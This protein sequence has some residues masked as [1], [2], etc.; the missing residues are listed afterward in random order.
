MRGWG[1]GVPSRDLARSF[2]PKIWPGPPGGEGGGP[3]GGGGRYAVG[4]SGESQNPETRWGVILSFDV[5]TYTA[6][7]YVEGS[8]STATLPVAK[9]LT[10]DLLPTGTKVAI[11]SFDPSNPD[12]AIVVGTYG[13]VGVAWVTTGI[14]VDDCVTVGKLAHNIDATGIGFDADKVDGLHAAELGGG[15][16]DDDSVTGAKISP[17]AVFG[18]SSK[19]LV[20]YVPCSN[21]NN[22]LYVA[23]AGDNQFT[24]KINQPTWGTPSGTTV[25][26]D[27]VTGQENSIAPQSASEIGHLVLR[28]TTRGTSALIAAVDTGTNVI[29]L[30]GN[31]P[32]GWRDNDDITCN[33]AVI[34]STY[35][36]LDLSGFLGA[37]VAA[38][39]LHIMWYDSGAAGQILRLHP[40]EAVAAGKTQEFR[41]QVAGVYF[42]LVTDV[43][44]V[45]QKIGVKY[46]ASGAATC[47][48]K[49]RALGYFEEAHV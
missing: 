6:Q 35:F 2:H 15:T 18:A 16:P 42:N 3:R 45:S 34:D 41:N 43:P 20:N 21:D 29:T 28:N 13:G 10:A 46:D 24:A 5:A 30:T 9:H 47:T 14:L 8:P 36:D 11:L 4:P 12:D 40:Y 19:K 37:T 1:D 7:V 31:V 49:L 33:S 26:Y 23:L 39:K 32:S 38:I 25:A 44:V 27:T 17:D 22:V 48:V